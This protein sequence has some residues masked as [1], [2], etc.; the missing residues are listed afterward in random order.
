MR[1]FNGIYTIASPKGGHRTLSIRTQA[2]DATFAPGK[3][4]LALLSGPN[5]EDDYRGFA[6][7]WDNCTMGVWRKHRGTDL[8]KIGA[9]L[10]QLLREPDGQLYRLGYRV[11]CSKR[12]LRCNRTLTTPQS[13]DL[14]YGP[15]CAAVLG[16]PWGEEYA[17]RLKE[18]VAFAKVEQEDEE[19]AFQSDPDYGFRLRTGGG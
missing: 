2:P 3:R 12:C 19:K 11:E 17:E 10:L 18:K 7:L 15:E 8:E 9:M 16:L 5:N 14:G 6:F 4:I 13:L 1:I